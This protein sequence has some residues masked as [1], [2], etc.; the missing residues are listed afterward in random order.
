MPRYARRL[1]NSVV[2]GESYIGE[3][4]KVS[5][6]AGFQIDSVSW[7]RVD[8]DGNEE[9]IN[10]FAGEEKY[11]LEESDIG[12]VILPIV[13]IRPVRMVATKPKPV[14][15]ILLSRPIIERATVADGVTLKDA[16]FEGH[17][18]SILNEWFVDG[19][20]VGISEPKL[21]QEHQ[22]L[23]IKVV[24]TVSNEFGS[25][26]TES[27]LTRICKDSEDAAQYSKHKIVHIEEFR[28]P[29]EEPIGQ[30]YSDSSFLVARA[31]VS[32]GNDYK[33]DGI[34]RLLYFPP[35]D[36]I[37]NAILKPGTGVVGAGPDK[38]FIEQSTN[39]PAFQTVVGGPESRSDSL[40][41]LIK[42]E[43]EGDKPLS[44]LPTDSLYSVESGMVKDVMIAGLT[45]SGTIKLAYS[46]SPIV[47]DVS[48][49]VL[50]SPNG[51]WF[52]K[53]NYPAASKFASIASNVAV[54]ID[55]PKDD[56]GS[57]YISNGVVSDSECGILVVGDDS[58]LTAGGYIVDC[59]IQEC[60]TGIQTS[61]G[62][63]IEGT[64]IQGNKRNGVLIVSERTLLSN[65]PP[66]MGVE[67]NNSKV[68]ANG[69]QGYGDSS[70]G[71]LFSSSSLEGQDWLN[72]SG[73]TVGGNYGV[74]ILSNGYTNV[75]SSHPASKIYIKGSLI[76]KNSGP[77][78]RVL[79]P[80]FEMEEF[81]ID[82]STKVESNGV[83]LS[84]VPLSD[85]VSI[86]CSVRSLN[87]AGYFGNY[88]ENSSTQ[89][90]GVAVR[91]SVKIKSAIFTPDLGQHNYPGGV[92][93]NG[94]FEKLTNSPSKS[95][96]WTPEKIETYNYFINPRMTR[97]VLP[98]VSSGT[99]G[100]D[101]AA[102]V[103]AGVPSSTIWVK[104]LEQGFFYADFTNL[105]SWSSMGS[106]KQFTFKIYVRASA[107]GFVGQNFSSQLI[108]ERGDMSNVRIEP[109]KWYKLLIPFYMKGGLINRRLGIGFDP[110]D[111]SSVNNLMEFA[112][113]M[114][115]EG[116]YDLSYFDGN[117]GSWTGTQNLSP[118]KAK[119]LFE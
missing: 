93:L 80:T 60:G 47:Y 87:V 7:I 3:T 14:K 33:V 110:D 90:V 85:G 27:E 66:P 81:N 16:T 42:G 101:S 95:A 78:V 119:V 64:N 50:D 36:Y 39:E 35:G 19:K 68:L 44:T 109:G 12:Y 116:G 79:H 77:G 100:S 103:P 21:T 108:A 28:L 83:D 75:E 92:L 5:A 15:P 89:R 29:N 31:I 4:L 71:I 54:R 76:E 25:F 117:G 8:Q 102:D 112:G 49:D 51:I 38:T 22:G 52:Y 65:S 24:Q 74:G 9:E 113:G 86:E 59:D 46:E 82:Q 2:S 53:S 104:N 107:S 40:T 96:N 30:D 115:Y 62:L 20:S 56:L 18:V 98:A 94:E 13:S 1:T 106:D 58:A 73:T 97:S 67:I 11:P 105:I 55:M 37:L 88:D 69:L 91:K 6:P 111:E 26:V 114:V 72:V 17:G 63:K 118:S 10:D 57:F 84:T 70:A 61:S 43:K 41:A 34:P 23:I 32:M 48:L 99:V 45:S